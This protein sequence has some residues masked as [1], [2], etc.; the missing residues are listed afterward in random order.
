M[1]LLIRDI[2]N[3]NKNFRHVSFN[4]KYTIANRILALIAMDL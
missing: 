1:N 3:K 2:Q 4:A